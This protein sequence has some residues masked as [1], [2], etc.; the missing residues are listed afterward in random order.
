VRTRRL[1]RV[2]ARARAARR[3][4]SCTRRSSL[5]PELGERGAPEIPGADPRTVPAYRAWAERAGSQAEAFLGEPAWTPERRFGRAFERLAL[6]GLAARAR[7]ELLLTL[8]AAGPT[9]WRPTRCTRQ[10]DDA[11][12]L[13]AKRLLVSGDAMLLERRAAT[14]R[15]RRHPLGALDR[16]LAVWGEGERRRARADRRSARRSGCVTVEIAELDL[17]DARIAEARRRRSSALLPRSRPTCSARATLPALKESPRRAA[18]TR[19]HFL[20]AYEGERLVGAISWKRDRRLVDIHRLVVHPTA[21]AAGSPARC[22]RA[23]GAEPDAQ[24]WV[25]ATGAANGPR[26]ASTSARL[27]AVSRAARR[28]LD[29]DRDYERRASSA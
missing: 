17:G 15:R 25:V 9:S 11:T 4:T 24:R 12:T 20:G 13:A 16:A 28:R 29:H 21:S 23:R 3:R 7:Y 2:P 8:G 14:S 10:G 22:S 1:A 18:Q 19:E 6:P 5:A 26:A 27:P